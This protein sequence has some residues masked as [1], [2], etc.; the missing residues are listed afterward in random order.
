M[1][2]CCQWGCTRRDLLPLRTICLEN[3]GG[4]K[5]WMS[6][7]KNHEH[8]LRVSGSWTVLRVSPL[9]ICETFPRSVFIS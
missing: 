8:A 6:G 7:E 5:L 9:L 2:A 3:A 1:R 4:L